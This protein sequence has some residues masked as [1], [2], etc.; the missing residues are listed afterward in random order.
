MKWSRIFAAGALL[1]LSLIHIYA[2]R[3]AALRNPQT[4]LFETLE[5]LAA[6]LACK[7][8]LLYTSR[9]V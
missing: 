1:V 2:M 4:A 3:A 9:C 8:C 6:V 5:K 7:A